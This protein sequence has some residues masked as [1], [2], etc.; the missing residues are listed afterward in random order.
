MKTTKLLAVSISQT[1]HEY[2]NE[3]VAKGY[4]KSAIVRIAL[5]LLMKIKKKQQKEI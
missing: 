1:H 4:N 5:D 3:L 2:L